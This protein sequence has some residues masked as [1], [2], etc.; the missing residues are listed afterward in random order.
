MTGDFKA[1]MQAELRR[2]EAEQAPAVAARGAAQKLREGRFSVNPELQYVRRRIKKE[3]AEEL[4]SRAASDPSGGANGGMPHDGAR[5][6]EQQ[7]TGDDAEL[8]DGRFRLPP[9]ILMSLQTQ[10]R[11]CDQR[12]YIRIG[13]QVAGSLQ[14]AKGGIVIAAFEHQ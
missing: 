11:K 10:E 14:K 1:R 5:D 6:V 4:K 12:G 7:P 9:S 3:F 2:W 13:R 8:R